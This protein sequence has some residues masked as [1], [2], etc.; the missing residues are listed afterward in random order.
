MKSILFLTSNNLATNPRLVKEL[1]LARQSYKCTVFYFNLSNWSD[2]LDAE[3]CTSMPD[4]VFKI[5][6][7]G[8]E[9]LSIW[10]FSSLIERLARLLYPTFKG[11]LRLN[12]FAHSKRS[13]L[14]WLAI[15]WQPYKYDLIIAHNLASLYPA[16]S[17]SKLQ[18]TPFAFDL[19]DY[20]PGEAIATDSENEINRRKYLMKILLPAGSYVSYAS[21]LIGE[22]FQNL[23]KDK[24]KPKH[25]LINNS[26][27]SKDFEVTQEIVAEKLSLVWFSQN[28]SSG[29]GLELVVPVLYKFR[30]QISL[31]L[32]GN[33][34]NAFYNKFLKLYD[35]VLVYVLPM[36]QKELHAILPSFD[37]GLAIEL[38][39]ADSN[40][41]K[42]LTNKIFA[43]SQ[44]GLYILATDTEAQKLFINQNP[45]VGEI[46]KQTSE[47]FELAIQATLTNAEE[48]KQGKM[49]RQKKARKLAW[50]HESG[51]I[52]EVWQHFA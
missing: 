37:I 51:K 40:R 29:R 45:N 36:R 42:C 7:T 5:L 22:A 39:A 9:A 41:D 19:E 50:E 12:A 32:I 30:N 1:E 11:S 38:S 33:L 25:F 20:H 26:F 23:L 4:V 17:F 14:L 6:P 3:I 18:N 46:M 52:L 49:C 34:N 27:P 44:A 48:I 15:R 10:L 47:D 24:I 2:T 43:Y 21:P 28:I 35:D 16:Y 8:K 31:T 13:L